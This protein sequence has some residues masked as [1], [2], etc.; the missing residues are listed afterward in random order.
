MQLCDFAYKRKRKNRRA[1][2]KKKKEDREIRPAVQYSIRDLL[3]FFFLKCL[4]SRGRRQRLSKNEENNC[5]WNSLY[6]VSSTVKQ[7]SVK[8]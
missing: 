2:A 4:L 7:K 5:G 1:K 8:K 6:D 3:I